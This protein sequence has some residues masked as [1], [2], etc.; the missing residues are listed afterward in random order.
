MTAARTKVKPPSSVS[1]TYSV[2]STNVFV[3]K[4]GWT[5]A[6]SAWPNSYHVIYK[7]L[8]ELTTTIASSYR[9]LDVQEGEHPTYAISTVNVNL[10]EGVETTPVSVFIPS[11]PVWQTGWSLAIDQNATASIAARASDPNGTALTY[12]KAGGTA[13]ST[14]TVSSAGLVT[15]GAT[16]GGSYTLV[17][18][19]NN[20]VLTSDT[21]VSLTVNSIAVAPDALASFTA[22]PISPTQID[23]VWTAPASGPTPTDYDAAWSPN[24]DAPW[25]PL[26][27]ITGQV[28]GYQH[29]NLSPNTLYY[30]R[31]RATCGV[32][33]L[34]PHTF[35]NATTPPVAT[36][37]TLFMS[38]TFADGKIA[39]QSTN[40]SQPDRRLNSGVFIKCVAKVQPGSAQT[41]W[42]NISE[43]QQQF[44]AAEASPP[45]TEE[46]DVHVC[47]GETIVQGGLSDTITPREGSYF[48]RSMCYPGADRAAA[49]PAP[50]Y[51]D[52]Y[53]H[54]EGPNINGYSDDGA[55]QADKCKPRSETA[56]LNRIAHGIP[57]D[58]RF[59]YG[60]SLRLHKDFEVCTNANGGR[61]DGHQ[62]GP[63][64]GEMNT[65][66]NGV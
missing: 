7:D 56:F 66:S 9:D 1:V 21:T 36:A 13:P 50:N 42:T 65:E 29:T 15:V 38:A 35:A 52:E 6:Q 24:N 54:Y 20:G 43:G 3:A 27:P 51:V 32:S 28:F 31:A 26:T 22:T 10:V 49:S 45:G 17:L 33:L 48:M 4:L 39:Q 60:I 59:F 34:G 44:S 11:Y 53:R 58:T 57:Y 5:P 18:R 40:R 46:Y 19:A 41:K 8:E 61:R 64:L 37:R 16:A 2:I 12:S 30:Y 62:S 47:N 25:T 55:H 23:L 14:V 63:Q